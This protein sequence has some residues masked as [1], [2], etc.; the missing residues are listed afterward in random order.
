[1]VGRPDP[2]WGERV[3]AVIVAGDAPRPTLAEVRD[4]VR[5]ELPAYAAPKAIEW[6]DRLPTTALGKIR[7]AALRINRP[8]STI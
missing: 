4:A 8:A 7:R 3:V 1:M 6:V 5:A 2:E